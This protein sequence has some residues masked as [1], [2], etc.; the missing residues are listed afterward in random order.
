ML[1][2]KS[3]TGIK[4]TGM[5][6]A[7][8]VVSLF[9]LVVTC[10]AGDTHSAA[11]FGKLCGDYQ[12]DLTDAGAGTLIV[13]FLE[14]DGSVWFQTASAAE[15]RRLDPVAGRSNA[16]TTRDPVEGLYEI[17]FLEDENSGLSAVRLK[18]A[19]MALDVIGTRLEKQVHF[20]TLL[21]RLR[22]RDGLAETQNDLRGTRA[23]VFFGRGMDGHS[24]L[25]IG[26]AFQWMGCDV[27]VVDPDDI[28]RG[29]LADFDVLAFPGGETDPDPWNEL[30]PAGKA[31]VQE[32]IRNGGGYVGICF[33]A[34]FAATSGDFWGAEIGEREL[35]LD[36]FAGEAHCGQADV[37]PRGSWPLMTDLAVSHCGHPITAALPERIRVVSYPNGPYFQP[38]KGVEVTIVATF[39]ATGNPAMVAFE[40]GGGRVFLSGPHPEIEVDSDRDGS[41]RF[42]ELSDQGSEWPLLL[43]AMRWITEPRE[44]P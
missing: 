38:N 35:Y 12:F 20:P 14:R 22:S 37:A 21:E 40:Y 15:P 5:V 32:F 4:V 19:A 29:L 31:K 43:A 28:K 33:G 7:A 11:Q 30:G 39:A 34:L 2:P 6:F 3:A 8:V 26:R 23:A 41:S 42:D 16:F 25:A 44:A 24:A 27:D 10:R 18:N 9:A 1:H 36:L 13:K 17:E